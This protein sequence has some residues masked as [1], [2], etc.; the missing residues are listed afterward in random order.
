MVLYIDHYDSFSST[1]VDYIT[2][3][4]YQVS[5]VKTDEQINN[6]EQYSHIIIGPGPGHPDELK[7]IYPIIEYCQQNNLPLLG[8]CLGHQLIAQYYG[9]KII[10]AK[11]IYHGKL[12]EIKQLQSS[13]L[14]KDH[15]LKF[16]VTRYH[17][18]IVNDIKEPLITLASTDSDEIMSF[19]HQNANIFGVQ[20]HP[21]AYLT[22]Y[23][24]LTLKNFLA[25]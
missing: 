24:L 7:N 14:Y 6:I 21:E 8:I 18:L 20:Y 1:I 3:L 5:M 11:Q 16:A 10:K 13:A 9:A 17:S 12:S 2:Y 19:A 23:G 4:G 22:E 15:P 25:L